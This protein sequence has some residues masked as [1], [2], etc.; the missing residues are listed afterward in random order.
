MWLT[1]TYY[2]S[3]YYKHKC[4]KVIRHE[5]QCKMMSCFFYRHTGLKVT[6]YL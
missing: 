3:K 5:M 1:N 2:F 4:C 6:W